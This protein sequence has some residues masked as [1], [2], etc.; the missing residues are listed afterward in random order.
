MHLALF[1]P[2]GKLFTAE[3]LARACA[4]VHDGASSQLSKSTIV[5]DPISM[6]RPPDDRDVR[7]RFIGVEEYHPAPDEVRAIASTL[8]ELRNL[9]GSEIGINF[10]GTN[11]R[12]L[13]FNLTPESYLAQL[14][15]DAA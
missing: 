11:M 14:Q 10:L 1:V 3:I 15:T 5:V 2:Q 9:F 7:I 8:P 6:N 12:G 13:K 4:I